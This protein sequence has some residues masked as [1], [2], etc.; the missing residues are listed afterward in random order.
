MIMITVIVLQ[1]S[2]TQ[3]LKQTNNIVI[4]WIKII[5]IVIIWIKIINIVIIWIKILNIVITWIK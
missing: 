5:N 3:K 2:K 4:M 1:N